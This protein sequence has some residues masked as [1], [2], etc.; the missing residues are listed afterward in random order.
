MSAK[1]PPNG[2]TAPLL[3]DC[4]RGVELTVRVGVPLVTL[5]VVVV[6]DVGVEV[7]VVAEVNVAASGDVGNAAWTK[8]SSFS[9]NRVVKTLM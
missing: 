5:V 4:P 9:C 1:E 6:V 3:V 2:A 8:V 7:D